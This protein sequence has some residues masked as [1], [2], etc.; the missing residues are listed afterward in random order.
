MNKRGQSGW[1]IGVVIVFLIVCIALLVIILSIGSPED[2]ENPSQQKI[3]VFLTTSDIDS[4]AQ[5]SANYIIFENTTLI[6]QGTT[7][8]DS[9]IELNIP[10][11]DSVEVY[12]WNEDYYTNKITKDF[13]NYDFSF[14]SS[15]IDCQMNKIGNL[16]VNVISGDLS[17]IENTIILNLTSKDGTFNR[18]GAC[19]S[20]SIGIYAVDDSSNQLFC[21]QGNWT[22]VKNTTNTYSCGNKQEKEQCARIEKGNS[23][24]PSDMEI[25]DR[26]NGIVDKCTYFGGII[27]K[28]MNRQI[29]LNVATYDFKNS[30]DYLELT[31]FDQDKRYIINKIDYVYEDTN[32]LDIGANDSTIRI[33]YISP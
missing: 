6:K 23:C 19:I 4:K 28:D 9:P 32:K 16:E 30:F 26:F 12:C 2:S 1:I 24:M 7:N 11:S 20:W 8:L 3:K 18:L 21:N 17:K 31:F 10:I 15:K 5:I 14:N 27:E 33:S 29:T 13:T 22:K 25:P